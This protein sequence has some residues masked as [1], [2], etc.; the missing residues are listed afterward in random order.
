MRMH[1]CMRRYAYS[2]RMQ[3]CMRRARLCVHAIY[4]VYTCMQM[5]RHASVCLPRIYLCSERRRESVSSAWARHGKVAAGDPN[6]PLPTATPT[7]SE[8]QRRHERARERARERE[9]ERERA[10]ASEREREKRE[11]PPPERE[12]QTLHLV[13][14]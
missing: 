6:P 2:M 11:T 1:C 4:L 10:R 7:F 9:S 13:R 3:C 14:A 8:P 5:P 12:R